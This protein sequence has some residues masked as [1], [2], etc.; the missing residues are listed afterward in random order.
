MSFS[1]P[2]LNIDEMLSVAKQYGYDGI[3]LR[4]AAAHKH[5]LE[6]ET[7]ADTRRE[8]KQKIADS[9]IV[10]SCV[11]TSCKYADPETAGQQVDETMRYIDLAADAGAARIRVFGGKI[12][13]GTSRQ[14][15][16][17]LLTRSL[18]SVADHAQERGITICAETHDDWCDPAHLAEVMKRVNHQSI[19]V[20][21]D[22]M[23]PV[24]VAGS[25][26]DE[27]FNA[28]KPWIRHVHFHDGSKDK[29]EQTPIGKG[30]I[31]HQ[32]AVELLKS[33]QYDG[34]LSGEWINW[35]PYEDHLPRE[36]ATMKRF[37]LL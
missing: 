28:L 20:N 33:I 19:A 34:Y 27:A 6:L 1:C 3:E 10:L 5:G 36:L 14:E 15:A 4:T 32:R 30:A 35:E 8:I 25:T 9:G 31:D 13:E 23:H 7:D 11:A 22:I 17:D 18:Q 21:W 12:P 2:E 16:I 24:R 37:E 26:M 29:M